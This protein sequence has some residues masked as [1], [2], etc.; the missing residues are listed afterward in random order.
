MP[1]SK[2]IQ[3]I[4]IAARG[5]TQGFSGPNEF[6]RGLTQGL[7]DHAPAYRIH[8]Y[9]D[10][11][12]ALGLFPRAVERVLPSKNRVVWDQL[13]LPR[14]LRQDK[15]DV[16]IFPKGP[17]PLSVP[18]RAVSVI[19]DLGYFYPEIDAYRTL[20]TLYFRLAL[21]LAA[22]QAWGLFAVSEYTRQDVI[23]TLHADPAKVITIHEAPGDLY[24]PVTDP[25][26]LAD[27]RQ[28]YQLREPFMFYPT[29]ISPRKNISRVLGALEAVKDQIPHHLVLTGGLKWKT[30]NLLERLNGPLAERVHLLGAVR[31]EDMPAL[32][33]LAQFVI[34]PSLFEGFGLPVVEAFRCGTP[35]LISNLTSLPEIAGDA[36]LIVDGGRAD[37]IRGG[38]LRLANDASLRAELR[39]RGLARAETFTWEKTIR[40][41]VTWIERK[42]GASLPKG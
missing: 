15:I 24:R 9:Y 6:I 19:H 41:I 31:A 23:R 2:S 36:A 7:L 8:L 4:A 38:L 11:P 10:S 3:T 35:V 14:A 42:Q 37:S 1:A 12:D 30:A 18:C 13:L 5:L 34:Y 26:R 27:V 17:I 16:A 39:Q 20:D 29:S 21:P 28:R 25:A 32:Y 33:S 40:R 22:R